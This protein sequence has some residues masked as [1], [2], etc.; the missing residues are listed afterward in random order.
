MNK[1][2]NNVAEFMEKRIS[3]KGNNQQHARIQTQSWE[4]TTSRLL[5]VR[6]AVKKDKKQQI[7]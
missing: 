3:T 2:G 4:N 7:D 6:S 5:V 1:T